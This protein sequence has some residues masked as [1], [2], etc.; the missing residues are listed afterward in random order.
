ML[1][2]GMPNFP[3]GVPRVAGRIV[4]YG[5]KRNAWYV[6]HE[7]RGRNGQAYVY[8]AF[9]FWGKI[10]ST[11]IESDYSGMSAD[12]LA[13]FRRQQAEH[14]ARENAKRD[15]RAS[16]AANRA[17]EQWKGAREKLPDGARCPYLE[18]KLV[19]PE[20]NVRFFQD[21]TLLV[22]MIRYDVTELQLQD[23]EYKG[24][25][26]LV[27]LQKIAPDGT[28]RF[29]KGMA[30]RGAAFVLGR[31]PRNG[32]LVLFAE[33]FATGSSI[34]K[35]T[36]YA[37]AV[38]VVFDAYNLEDAAKIFRK[39]YPKSIFL[40]CADD[41][42]L[43]ICERH[44]DEGQKLAIAYSADRPAWCQCNPGM[45]RAHLAAKQLGASVLLPRFKSDTRQEK[46]TDFNDL[47]A[48]E[49]IDA[50]AAQIGVAASIA[51][52][53]G[54]Q[55]AAAG[56]GGKDEVDW[57][58]HKL[59]LER[60]VQ[61]YPSDTAYDRR[62]G[63]IV[64]VSHMRL[65]FGEDPVTRW[66]ESKQK[67]V[68][69]LSRVVFDPTQ[70][71][72][73]DTHINLFKGF[74]IDPSPKA[75]CVKLLELLQVLCGEADQDQAPITDHLLKWIAYPLQHPGA[76]MQTA[77]VMHGEEGTGKNLFWGA[78]S[79]IY[80]PHGG[81][82]TQMQLQSQF[83]T[84]LSAKLFLIANEVVTRHEMRHLVGYLKHLV[85]EPDIYINR[86]MVDERRENNH[87]NLVFLSNELQPLQI[88][89]RDRRYVVIK[90]TQVRSDEF[91]RA[92]KAE[93]E[94]GGA[95]ALYHYLLELELGD[96]NE[97]TKPPMTDAKRALI[98]YGMPP[99]Q[100]FWKDLHEETL[101]LPYCPALTTDVYRAYRVYCDRNG[102]KQPAALNRFKPEFMSL[103][104]VRAKRDRIPDPD[105]VA[106]LHVARDDD[107]RQRWIFI[108]GDIA[109]DPENEKM[110]IQ[111]GVK[112][113]RQALRNY[114]REGAGLG[115]TEQAGRYVA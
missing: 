52:G 72:D 12:E 7:L 113:F 87:A 45:T 54:V 96:F 53:A 74:A 14:E 95:A 28:K 18:R 73:P 43:T 83:N 56:G 77:V 110:R 13:S 48:R 67:Q 98:D 62:I 104:G 102:H 75:S 65:R 97:H 57:D 27:G 51:G 108:M 1:G 76:K 40:F 99:S 41:D 86:K 22:P 80:G 33:G 66:L 42:Y 100:L 85:T 20:K 49:G 68:V 37:I 90:T 61:I 6:L 25:R 4:R 2:A 32:E 106:E 93:L 81:F 10:P 109:S 26:R 34:R 58:Q 3:D 15:K 92:V 103:N 63:E 91:Y 105:D 23:P 64:K 30:K 112:D 111:R 19:P 88:G 9:G 38:V 101:G 11:K 17:L 55:A 16:E 70:R 36:G 114:L 79:T 107:L 78:V 44:K 35:A 21:G 94:K 60:F 46:D 59:L 24:P 5:P 69:L 29:N 8:G 39:L 50:V 115:S 71:V 89:P 82:I 47:H 31:M 84:W